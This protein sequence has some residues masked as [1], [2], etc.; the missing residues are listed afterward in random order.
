MFFICQGHYPETQNHYFVTSPKE[1]NLFDL[2]Q[3]I[4]STISYY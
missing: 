2:T 1:H 3:V 4:K